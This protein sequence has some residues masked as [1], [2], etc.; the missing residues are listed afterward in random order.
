M[1]CLYQQPILPYL[2]IRHGDQEQD[3]EQE[4]SQHRAELGQDQPG[5]G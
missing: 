5:P 1:S 4:Q 3:H 2:G